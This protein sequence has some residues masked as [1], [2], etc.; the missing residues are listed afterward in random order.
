MEKEMNTISLDYRIYFNKL[1]PIIYTN[2]V[3][4]HIELSVRF[5]VHP[6]KIRLVE[7]DIW[8]KIIDSYQ[9]GEINLAK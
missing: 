5:L 3:D 8:L 6:K 2:I 7:N 1:K 4:N 9:K